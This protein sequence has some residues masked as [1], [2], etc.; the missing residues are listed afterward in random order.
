M[1][2]AL[3]LVDGQRLFLD[4]ASPAVLPAG[5]RAAARAAELL[6][7][8]R[9]RGLPVAHA[10]F[11][12]QAGSPMARRWRAVAPG[13]RWAEVWPALS[14]RRGEAAVLKHGY[15]AFRGTRLAAWLRSRDVRRLAVA[16]FM[17][18]LCV[19]ATA[20]DAFAEGFEVVVA[21]D[22]CAARTRGLHAA[23][24]RLMTRACAR[25]APAAGIFR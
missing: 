14:P 23:A 3:L 11:E 10:R 20:L 22:A 16:G 24:L 15:S 25:T 5:A 6:A 21:R 18:D 2:D 8:A 4:P 12:T 17:T 7:R 9:A 19:L 1:T 13:S